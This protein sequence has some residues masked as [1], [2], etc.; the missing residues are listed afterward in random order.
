MADQRPYFVSRV[1]Y[2]TV[3]RTNVMIGILYN[4]AISL[5]TLLNFEKRKIL[6]NVRVLETLRWNELSPTVSSLEF[7]E[8]LEETPRCSTKVQN[9]SNTF[10]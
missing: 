4:E 6:E 5:D 8:T 10:Q 3:R 7:P 1:N 9:F 2:P